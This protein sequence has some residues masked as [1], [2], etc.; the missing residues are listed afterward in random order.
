[1]TTDLLELGTDGP[2]APPRA[3]GELV[4]TAPW[5][6]RSFAMTLALADQGVFTLDD[7]REHLIAAIATWEAANDEDE[8]YHYYERWQEALESIVRQSELVSDSALAGRIEE[9]AA[10]PA[11]HDHGHDHDHDHDHDHSH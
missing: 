3:N 7:F 8:P 2:E 1:M 5:E 11:G 9:F 4:F 6:S 10:R